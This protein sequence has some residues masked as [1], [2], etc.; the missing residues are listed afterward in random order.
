MKSALAVCLGLGMGLSMFGCAGASPS[1]PGVRGFQ[2]ERYLGRWFEIARLDFRFERD[3]DNTTAQYSLR[4]DGTIA[5]LNQGY[6][7]KSSKWQKATA[8]ARF[9]GADTVGELEVSFFGP[10]YS[11]YNVLALDSAYQYA[12]V[13]GKDNGYLWIL[14]RTNDLPAEVRHRYLEIAHRSAFDTGKLIWVKHDR[15]TP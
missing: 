6:N 3:L 10:F 14:S 11:Q 5:V 15:Q 8:K 12:L 2:K 13:A 4:D 7:T 9:R 1:F